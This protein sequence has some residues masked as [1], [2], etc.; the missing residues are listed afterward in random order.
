M[1]QFQFSVD[2]NEFASSTLKRIRSWCDSHAASSVIVHSFIGD[3]DKDKVNEVIRTIQ[4]ELPFSIYLGC[5]SNGGILDGVLSNEQSI[6]AVTILEDVNSKAEVFQYTFDN[7]EGA[8][9][10]S[11]IEDVKARPWV[12]GIEMLISHNTFDIDIV[13]SR[14]SSLDPSIKIFGGAA[15]DNDYTSDKLLCYSSAG[16]PSV[17][18]IVFCLYGGDS[19]HINTSNVQGWKRLGRV[20]DAVINDEDPYVIDKIGGRPAFELYSKYL[21]IKDDGNLIRNTLE[22][23]LSFE[24]KGNQIMRVPRYMTQEGGLGLSTKGIIDSKIGLSYGDP[25]TILSDINRNG[26]SLSNF[27]PEVIFL[28]SCGS[29]K[30]FWGGLTANNETE[31]FQSLAPTFGFYTSEEFLRHNEELL[32]HNVTLVVVGMREGEAHGE[33]K[34][35]TMSNFL[36]DGPMSLVSRL[37]TFIDVTAHEIYEANQKLRLLSRTDQMTGLYNR[38]EIS[39]RIKLSNEGGD[40]SLIMIDIDDFKHVNDTFGHKEGDNVILALADT[41]KSVINSKWPSG[42][43]GRWGGEEFMILLPN[44]KEDEA[45]NIAESIRQTFETIS[46]EISGSQT[47]SL[48][49]TTKKHD[50]SSDILC[51]TVD[52]SLYTSKGNGKNRTTILNI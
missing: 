20:Y 18:S 44:C 1:R 37:A 7:N 38:T 6:V 28:F 15:F 39:S 35:F 41:M 2:N 11:F 36:N 3:V 51:S 17:N 42:S 5:T 4:Q 23:P 46:F 8:I 45:Y 25:W 40:L 49:V 13:T 43:I 14:L 26:L 10:D 29:R 12:K 30:V 22:F 34:S 31:G 16:E 24:Y 9:M 33:K 47:I 50:V 32:H 27:A 52:K 21:N 48:G 19:L